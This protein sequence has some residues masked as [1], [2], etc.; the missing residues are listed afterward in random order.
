MSS[1][2]VLARRCWRETA[3][4]A[5]GQAEDWEP[6]SSFFD[7]PHRE[8]EFTERVRHR[9]G[10][11]GR[12]KHDGNLMMVTHNVNIAAIAKVSVAP[13]EMVLVEPDGRGGSRLLGRLRAQ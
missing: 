13:G 1:R 10:N 3:T 6:L 8:P 7:F 5:F 12:Q 4:L 11:F 2:S 9:I